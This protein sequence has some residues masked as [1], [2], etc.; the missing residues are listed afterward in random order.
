MDATHR[1]LILGAGGFVGSHLSCALERRFGC[2]AEVVRTSLKANCQTGV[3]QLDVTDT[4]SLL[5]ALRSFQ[6]T[7]VVNLAGLSAPLTSRQHPELAWLLHAHMPEKLGRLIL[8]WLPEC[9]FLHVSSGLVYGRTAATGVLTE[10]SLLRPVNHYAV[11]KAAGDIAL[12]ALAEEGLKC[13]RLRPFNHTG[14]GQTEEFAVPAFASQIARISIG[15]CPPVIKVGNLDAERDFLDVRDV[16]RAY[17]T[18]I[19]ASSNLQPGSVYNISSGRPITM[20][21]LLDELIRISNIEV[22]IVSDVDRQRSNELSCI[23]GD[24]NLL[25]KDIGWSPAISLETTLIDTFNYF[26]S[27]SHKTE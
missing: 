18:I 11:T 12:G 9:W 5:T 6:P 13:L 25:Q 22:E 4:S 19:S 10:S 27:I 8:E 2:T 20:R 16:V 24:S 1:I 26:I 21:R 17:A 23:S 7:H 14:P 3:K 15:Q